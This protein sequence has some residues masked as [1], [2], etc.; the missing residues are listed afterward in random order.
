[1]LEDKENEEL[2]KTGVTGCDGWMCGGKF[3][4]IDTIVKCTSY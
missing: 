2:E 1:M 3:R 4:R